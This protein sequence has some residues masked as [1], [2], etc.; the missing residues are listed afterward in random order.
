LNPR[1][2]LLIRKSNQGDA[3][4]SIS[5]GLLM[6]FDGQSSVTIEA[7]GSVTPSAQRD[8]DGPHRDQAE[9]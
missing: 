8:R 9:K 6:P 7:G 1:A 5:P 2:L 3:P 4:A